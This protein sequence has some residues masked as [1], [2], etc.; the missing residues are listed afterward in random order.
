MAR[1]ADLEAFAKTHDLA[2]L[3]IGDLVQYRRRTEQLIKRLSQA[4]L[5]TIARFRSSIPNCRLTRSI[6][7][8]TSVAFAPTRCCSK[9][10]SAIS[11]AASPTR[12]LITISERPQNV[13]QLA[14]VI[15]TAVCEIR[16]PRCSGWR[17]ICA[18][19]SRGR[20]RFS[21]S[22]AVIH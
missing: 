12:S 21:I 1:G 13:I 18:G 2:I 20:R 10:S 6:T 14:E 19:R 16:S 8:A 9:R 11:A 22:S 15:P 7:V 3:S 4:R 17:I 5:P